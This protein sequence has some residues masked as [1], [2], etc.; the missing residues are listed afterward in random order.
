[1]FPEPWDQGHPVGSC[2][3][4]RLSGGS[5]SHRED[6]VSPESHLRQRENTLGEIP[7]L[8][9]SPTLQTPTRTSLQLT[10]AGFYRSL[11]PQTA[12]RVSTAHTPLWSRAEEGQTIDVFTKQASGHGRSPLATFYM[13]AQNITH[14]HGRGNNKIQCQVLLESSSSSSIT[15]AAREPSMGRIL[16]QLSICMYICLPKEILFGAIL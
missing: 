15:T 6:A 12:C 10:E 9:P 7:W 2:S 11:R 1:M 16:P 3:R 5:L 14:P 8:F 4:A 13:R